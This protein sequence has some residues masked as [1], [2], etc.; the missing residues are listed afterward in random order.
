MTAQIKMLFEKVNQYLRVLVLLAF[1]VLGIA[2]AL[3][4]NKTFGGYWGYVYLIVS[5][6]G[7]N[8]LYKYLF[9]K[10]HK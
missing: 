2:I 9:S 5:L 3:K 10:K 1:C 4:W 8:E 7:V 6:L